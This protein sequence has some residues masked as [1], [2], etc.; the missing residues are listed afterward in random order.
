VRL[1]ATPNVFEQDGHFPIWDL[2]LTPRLATA[3]SAGAREPQGEQE[4]N[5]S[6]CGVDDEADDTGA[7][8]NSKAMQ[9]PVADERADDAY[10][11]VA[12]ETETAAFDNL[13]RQSS[14]NEPDDQNDNQS[15][16]RQMHTLP[17]GPSH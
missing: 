14:G 9:K 4:H 10:G 17:L 16:V 3:P 11:R 2:A 6:D 13:T 8:M 1:Q 15:L 12:D 5:R 7:E